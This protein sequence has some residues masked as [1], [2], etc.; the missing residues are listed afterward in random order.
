MKTHG[1]QILLGDFEAFTNVISIFFTKGQNFRKI[2]EIFR[3]LYESTFRIPKQ[4]EIQN[5]IK[6]PG[7]DCYSQE[8]FKHFFFLAL[9]GKFTKG[10]QNNC[11]HRR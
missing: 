7:S 8:H 11:I 5:S 6:L 1:E 3:K 10:T 2:A 9:V 4:M